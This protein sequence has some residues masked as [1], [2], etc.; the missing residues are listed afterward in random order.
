MRAWSKVHVVLGHLEV[1]E[2]LPGALHAWKVR[3]VHI[4]AKPANQSRVL[5]NVAVKVFEPFLIL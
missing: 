1:E 5:H 4:S 3:M 2:V